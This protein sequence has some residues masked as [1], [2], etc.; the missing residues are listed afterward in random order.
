[1]SRA[2]MPLASV[3]MACAI[4]IPG[5]RTPPTVVKAPN[6]MTSRRDSGL[7]VMFVLFWNWGV[8][9]HPQAPQ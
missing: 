9:T 7:I 6:L 2:L 8:E 4:E 1:M 5:V 3:T